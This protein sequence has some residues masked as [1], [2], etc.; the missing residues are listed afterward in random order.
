MVLINGLEVRC[1]EMLY[2]CLHVY[3]VFTERLDVTIYSS[4]WW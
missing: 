2:G 4:V 3:L 1:I